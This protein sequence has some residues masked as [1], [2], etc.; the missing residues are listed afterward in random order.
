LEKSLKKVRGGDTEG[1]GGIKR[2]EDSKPVDTTSKKKKRTAEQAREKIPVSSKRKAMP[3]YKGERDEGD[4]PQNERR[5]RKIW[6][7]R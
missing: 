4:V 7:K 3:E 2:G 1:I 6:R 5:K